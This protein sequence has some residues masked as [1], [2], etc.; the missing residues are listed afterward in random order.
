MAETPPISELIK[1]VKAGESNAA[2]PIVEHFWNAANRVIMG[3]LSPPL[4]RYVGTSDI[5]NAA[6]RSAI[7]HVAGGESSVEDRDDF[8]HL[9]V[10]IIQRKAASAARH[11]K[12]G[13]RDIG[14]TI[15]F[16]DNVPKQ[17]ET[18][19]EYLVAEDFG[20]RVAAL[21][22]EEADEQRQLVG[23]L[24][25]HEERSA[26]EIREAVA[27]AFPNSKPPAIRTIQAWLKATKERLGHELRKEFGDE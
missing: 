23:V 5:A 14:R 26:G 10:A 17:A 11:A 1:R 25:I 7:S 8:W 13:Q 15:E 20:E 16:K 24:G 27:T 3:R 12:A 9:L 4:R 19:L 2:G 22:L 21:L 6:L 18:P